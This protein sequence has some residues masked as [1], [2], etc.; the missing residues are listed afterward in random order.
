MNANL[1]TVLQIFVLSRGT[2]ISI[3]NKNVPSWFHFKSDTNVTDKANANGNSLSI[4]KAVP[5]RLPEHCEADPLVLV[6]VY[7][8]RSRT[9]RNRENHLYDA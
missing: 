5:L 7:R 8:W 9:D 1:T 2:D 6:E 4:S 3:N